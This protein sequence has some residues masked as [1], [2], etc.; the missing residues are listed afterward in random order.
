MP[1]SFIVPDVK[2]ISKMLTTLL[3]R[4]VK[5]TKGDRIRTGARDKYTLGVFVAENQ[6]IV[7][8]CVTDFGLAANFGAALSL[9]PPHKAKKCLDE[10]EIEATIW[11]NTLEVYNVVSRYFHDAHEGMV[12]LGPTWRDGE[13]VPVDVRKFMRASTERVDLVV[14]IVGYGHGAMALIG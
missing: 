13:Q 1:P 9:F 3:G 12:Q 8:I 5:V 14:N 11:E 2:E 7:G 6:D 10:G 4:E